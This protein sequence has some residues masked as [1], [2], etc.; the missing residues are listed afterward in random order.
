MSKGTESEQIQ[1]GSHCRDLN[2]S[3][4]LIAKYS[5]AGAMNV[6]SVAQNHLNHSLIFILE[7]LLMKQALRQTKASK[8]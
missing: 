4:M 3:V 8:L 1:Y 7:S 5:K 6:S 2:P